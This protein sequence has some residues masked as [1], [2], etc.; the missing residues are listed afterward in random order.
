MILE[1]SITLLYRYLSRLT[2]KAMRNLLVA[3][4]TLMFSHAALADPQPTATETSD[5]TECEKLGKEILRYFPSSTYS[6]NRVIAKYNEATDRCIIM[7][8]QLRGK[9]EILS[10]FDGQRG[11]VIAECYKEFSII[12]GEQVSQSQACSYIDKLMKDDVNEQ[13]NHPE[14]PHD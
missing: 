11:S 6:T 3:C 4:G 1:H 7:I 8:T 9:E 2:G 12:K 5:R 10:L 14:N 13:N